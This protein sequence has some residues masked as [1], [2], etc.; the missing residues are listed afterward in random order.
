MPVEVIDVFGDGGVQLTLVDD[1]HPVQQLAAQGVHPALGDRVGL[2]RLR[3]CEQD[4]DA[5][6]GEDQH[7][8]RG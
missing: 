7:R 5:F 6:A 2:G 4:P 1:Q 8:R 3:R